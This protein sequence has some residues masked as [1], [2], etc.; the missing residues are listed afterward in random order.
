MGKKSATR[1]F[2]AFAAITLGAVVLLGLILGGS[3]RSE[4]T[5]RGLAQ[6]RSEAQLMAHTAVEPLLDGRPLSR[7]LSSTEQAQFHR[8]ARDA[9][10]GGDVQRLRLRD[11]AGAVVFSDDGSGFHQRPEDEALDA[12]HGTVV[13][14]LTRINTDSDDSGQAGP[15]SVEVYLPLFAG[16]ASPAGRR[17]RGVPALCAD[18][19]R[20]QR[21]AP[22]PLSEPP[23]G[24]AA[25]Y[26]VLFGIPSG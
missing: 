3:Y 14:R 23:V 7:G 9:V 6:G 12:A 22:H 13:A 19:G 1:Q 15:E 21:R 16:D 5:R 4:A 25:L 17:P 8:L 11:L 24:L 2:V 10:S 26:V 20:R 18:Q